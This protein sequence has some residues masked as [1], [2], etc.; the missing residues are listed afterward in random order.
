M[1]PKLSEYVSSFSRQTRR[2]VNDVLAESRIEKAE[3][4]K[5]VAKISSFSSA[6]DYIPSYVST[7]S[8]LQRQPIIDLFRDMDLRIQTNY[9]ISQSLSLLRSSMSAIFAGEIEK[10]ERDVVYLESFIRNWTFL[11]GEEDL[12]N[13]SFIENFDNDQNSHIYENSTYKIPD[14]AGRY[15][16]T[17]EY[18]TVDSLTD[19]L[20]F[21]NSYERS[22]VNIS[23]EDIK[24]IKY[25]TN[26]SK[27]YIT[28]DTGIENVLNNFSSNTWNLTIKSPLV[29]KESIFEREEFTRYQNGINLAASAQVAIEIVFNKQ[30]KATRI[31][32]SPNLS[33]GLF[34]TQ[35]VVES[36]STE[37]RVQTTSE[38]NKTAILS[39]PIYIDKGTDVELPSTGYIKSMI[40]FLSQKEYIRT[41]ISPLQSE[42]NFKMINQLAS[43]IRVERK[44]SHDKLQDMVIK[45]FIKDHARDYII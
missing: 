28:S 33:S 31:R 14:R 15:F 29:I 30:I 13:S 9:D 36:S 7:L 2:T 26:F 12:Y 10:L 35:I 40:I 24:E 5:L 4:G 8:P 25:H 41:K 44:N 22:L 21:S 37:S 11:S 32:L 20:K 23:K 18:A 3:I 34:I 42:S 43:A 27:D 39:S 45:Y 38:S 19:T 1:L 16:S 6:A 17:N